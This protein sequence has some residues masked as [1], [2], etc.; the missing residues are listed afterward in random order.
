[1]LKCFNLKG[2]LNEYYNYLTNFTL[3]IF[4]NYGTLD[5]DN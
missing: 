1:M 3:K 5:L 2:V 4:Y